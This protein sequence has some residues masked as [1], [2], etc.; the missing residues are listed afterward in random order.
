[1]LK[2][3]LKSH[4]FM[5]YLVLYK[6]LPNQNTYVLQNLLILFLKVVYIESF[7]A[8]ESIFLFSQDC[9]LLITITQIEEREAHWDI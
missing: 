1:M 5:L 9:K 3:C 4:F 2:D 6:D 8:N 7:M